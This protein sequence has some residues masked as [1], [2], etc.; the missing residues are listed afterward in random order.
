MTRRGSGFVRVRRENPC[1]VCGHADWCMVTPDG[2]ACICPRESRGAVRR[3]GEAGYLHRFGPRDAAEV[4]RRFTVPVAAAPAELSGLALRYRDALDPGR[5][6][7]IA[8]NLGLSPGSLARLGTGWCEASRAASFPMSDDTGRVIGV[9]LRTAD[10]KK[11]AVRG[12]RN[13]LFI[14]EGIDPTGLVLV[15]EG[16]TDTAALLDLGFA[17]VGRP[18]CTG[19]VPLLAGFVRRHRPAHVVVVSDRDGHGRGQDGASELAR[20][21]TLY[22]RSVRVILPPDGVKDARAW[23]RAGATRDDVSGVIDAAPPWRVAV[24]ARVVTAAA[25]TQGGNYVH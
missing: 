22:C 6:G 8:A 9:R 4:T 14:S 13:G 5:L 20:R 7:R 1:P 2:S 12:S 23:V 11:F 15:A 21:L 16:P 18:S 25:R 24:I 10:G 19:G 17:A 3:C